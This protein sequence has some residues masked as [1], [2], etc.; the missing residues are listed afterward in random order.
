V[1]TDPRAPYQI[2]TAKSS[3]ESEI[4]RGLLTQ[5]AVVDPSGAGVV[6]GIVG[7]CSQLRRKGFLEAG[8]KRS[9][10]L[11][12]SPCSKYQHE[13]CSK[14]KSSA[15]QRKSEQLGHT[16]AVFTPDVYSRAAHM[17]DDAAAKCRSGIDGADN[18]DLFR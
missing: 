5:R 1:I 2:P 9:D 4:G 18:P 17:Q 7:H 12:P 10:P 11:S 8:V 3:V 6:K 13:P 15:T 14:K 16:S